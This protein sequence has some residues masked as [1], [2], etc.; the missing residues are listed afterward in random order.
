MFCTKN[1]LL[2]FQ[3]RVSLLRSETRTLLFDRDSRLLAYSFKFCLTTFTFVYR[4]H[5]Q[6]GL[7]VRYPRVRPDHRHGTEEV[8]FEA[9]RHERQHFHRE[10]RHRHWD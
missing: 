2:S 5:D 6:T 10:H 4:Q 1:E 9:G 7:P 8:H 3:D